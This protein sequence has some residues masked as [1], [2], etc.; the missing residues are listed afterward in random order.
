VLPNQSLGRVE[1][2]GLGVVHT[3]VLIIRMN[4]SSSSEI[5]VAGTGT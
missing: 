4:D 2:L 1:E 3:T 5:P